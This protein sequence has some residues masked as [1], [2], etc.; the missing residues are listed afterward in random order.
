LDSRFDRNT[1]A[2]IAGMMVFKLSPEIE[3]SGQWHR[4]TYA[5]ATTAGYFAPSVIYSTQIGSYAEVEGDRLSLALDASVGAERLAEQGA[6]ALTA[7][8]RAFGLWS[9][10]SCALG[11]GAS[12]R[13][14]LEAYDAPSA[15]IAATSAGWRYGFASMSLRWKLG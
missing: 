3:I 9:M 11:G 6:T 8:R 1:R 7:W 12:V 14:E 13:L 10:I 15:A 4:L 5:H 2:H